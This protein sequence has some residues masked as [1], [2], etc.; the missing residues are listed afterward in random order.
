MTVP[1]VED[2]PPKFTAEIVE[3]ACPVLLRDLGKQITA[4]LERAQ[5][6]AEKAEQHRIAAAQLLVQAKGL[7][8]VGGFT[9]FHEKLCPDLGRSR[10][11]ELLAIATDKKSIEDTRASTRERVARHRAKKTESVTSPA[12]TNCTPINSFS[13]ETADGK[14][15][16]WDHKAGKEY[17]EGDADHAGGDHA[18]GDHADGDH[19]GD[20]RAGDDRA[21]EP[22]SD[23]AAAAAAAVHQLNHTELE[24]FFS[25]L[26]PAHKRAF[27]QKFGARNSDNANAEIA[28]L[29]GE[30]SALLTHAEQ[31]TDAIRKKLARI[32]KLTGFGGKARAKSPQSNAQL[33]HGAFA[34]GMGLAGPAGQKFPTMTMMPNGVDASGNPN[35]TDQP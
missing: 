3:G 1:A 28:T 33:D 29:V 2:Y 19:A 6:Y 27:E 4:H 22:A 32:K 13:A 11:Y 5:K 30:C 24:S 31:N 23:P 10:T 18:D 25:Q 15:I 16:L 7:C 9:A 21:E 17:V 26:S 20:D 8:D 35:F 34:R 14:V 12:V